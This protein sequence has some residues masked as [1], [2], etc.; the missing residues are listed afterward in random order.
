V[1]FSIH[2]E[3]V[4][5]YSTPVTFAPHVVRLHPRPDAGRLLAQTI[6]VEPV[7][8]SRI[9]RADRFG[10]TVSEV[11]FPSV[12][13]S[14]LSIAS[15]LDVETRPP[16]V[17]A[18]A[19]SLD[20]PALPW[21]AP[22]SREDLG[23]YRAVEPSWA[24]HAFAEDLRSTANGRPIAFLEALTRAIFERTDRGIR[25][26]GAAQ[27]PDVTLEQ[28][29]GA[30]RD[31]AL[32][33]LACCR[34]QGMA[35]RF[36]SGYQA[37]AQTPDGRSYLHAWAEVYVEGAGWCGWDAMHGIAAGEGHLAL[38]AAPDQGSTMPVEGGFTFSGSNVV[39]TLDWSLR[40][41]TA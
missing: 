30:C 20:L 17:L 9:E 13:A 21:T 28:R 38:C 16:Q 32:L 11:T 41:A 4:Y 8:I 25:T 6:L 2:H 34:S 18:H 1:R 23:A 36:V 14:V 12:S 7:P 19:R 24:V 39:S 27:P 5:R 29:R 31:V 26:E 33:F 35:A 3:S 22:P 15:T 37:E 10:N 40:I